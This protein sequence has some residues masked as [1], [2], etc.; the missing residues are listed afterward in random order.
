MR[1]RRVRGEENELLLFPRCHHN[2]G[3]AA[4]VDATPAQHRPAVMWT[5]AYHMAFPIID[6]NNPCSL[7][8][9]S[10]SLMERR[11]CRR[12]CSPSLC[13]SRLVEARRPWRAGPVRDGTRGHGIVLKFPSD[14]GLPVLLPRL[15]AELGVIV[16]RSRGQALGLRGFLDFTL[17]RAVVEILY[18]YERTTKDCL[19]ALPPIH[20]AGPA[21][22]LAQLAAAAGASQSVLEA[23]PTLHP[24]SR[25]R[26][27][28]L[29]A[30]AGLPGR[31]G[32]WRG[33]TRRRHRRRRRGLDS[34]AAADDDDG[35]DDDAPID[36]DTWEASAATG[37][38]A[39][40]VTGG[41]CGRG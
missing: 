13:V 18:E 11:R 31:R 14:K 39:A 22:R 4:C 36:P 19:R 16:I 34:A 26:R 10:P 9:Y 37:G 7:R 21:E 23:L 41:P 8:L 6:A 32:G 1:L 24:R 20:A 40:T 27:R 28:G 15:S 30:G 29:G 12:T 35:D 33:R 2:L 38:P 3:A 25:R 5:A 17:R